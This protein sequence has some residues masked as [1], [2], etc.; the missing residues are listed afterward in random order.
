M[1]PLVIGFMLTLLFSASDTPAHNPQQDSHDKQP[2]RTVILVH[3][4]A[5]GPEDM[6][7]LAKLLEKRGYR[8]VTVDLPL[9]FEHVQ[10]AAEVFA[11]RVENILSNLPDNEPVAMV[12]H[13]TGGL[14]IRYFL[15]HNPNHRQVTH[16]VLIATPNQGSTLARKLGDFSDLLLETLATL[17]SLQPEKI[18]GLELSVPERT[19]IG[20]IAGNK[21][22][23]LLGGLL[24]EEN[25]GRVEVESVYYPELDDF[26]ILGYSHKEIHHK[27][28]TAE[29]V[30]RFL[31]KG[32]FSR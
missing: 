3:G 15:S 2:G 26:V 8:P 13:S 21:T 18:S 23:M 9:T 11:K 16:A 12:G 30:D 19:S 29:L 28:A 32:S 4:Y 24:D 10:E 1:H 22:T 5:K 6:E 17:D 31:K 25:D 20:A 27:K 7:T 14:I